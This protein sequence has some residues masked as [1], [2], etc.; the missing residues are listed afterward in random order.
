MEQNTTKREAG[1]RSGRPDQEQKRSQGPGTSVDETALGTRAGKEDKLGPVGGG[2]E[3]GGQDWRNFSDEKRV[4]LTRKDGGWDGT[5]Y[6][7]DVICMTL[8]L[9]SKEVER[10]VSVSAEN[11]E[12]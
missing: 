4:V 8:C 1:R 12:E 2:L 10:N 3:K 5:L 7:S 9:G 11:E 6:R